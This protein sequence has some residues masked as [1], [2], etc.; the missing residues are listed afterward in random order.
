LMGGFDHLLLPATGA[1][2]GNHATV[3]LGLAEGMGRGAGIPLAAALADME[4]GA[5]L[6]QQFI[7]IE[8]LKF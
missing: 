1:G 3:L 4:T 6:Q 8:V 5:A 7:C 2:V